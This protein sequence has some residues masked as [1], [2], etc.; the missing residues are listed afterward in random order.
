MMGAGRVYMDW[1]LDTVGK[2]GPIGVVYLLHFNEPIGNP[3]NRRAMARHYLGFSSDPPKRF[4]RHTAGQGSAIVRYVMAQGIGFTVAAT[5]PGD[6][7]LERRLKRRHNARQFCPICRG[8][9]LPECVRA[10]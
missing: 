6:R 5:W 4:A 9:V 3:A 8:E 1:L 10:A 2:T 7:R